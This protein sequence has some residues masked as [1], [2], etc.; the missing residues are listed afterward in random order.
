MQE[1][2]AD[3]HIH[4]TESDSTLTPEEVVEYAHKRGLST[5]AITDHDSIGAIDSVKDYARKYDIEVIPGVELSASYD[6]EEIHL[7]GYFLDYSS[8][9]FLKKLDF[10]KAEREDRTKNIIDK[11]KLLGMPLLFD[12][13]RDYATGGVMGRAH[14]AQV[15]AHKGY[16][17]SISQAF[18]LYLNKNKSAYV[19]KYKLLPKDAVSMIREINGI[20]VVAHP[21]ASKLSGIIHRLISDGIDGIEVFHGEHKEMASRKYLK[22]AKDNKLLVTGGSD[23]HGMM[24]GR[25]FLGEVKIGN[26]YLIPIRKRLLKNANTVN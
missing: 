11:L 2:Y 12:E 1:R 21:Y 5:I 14:I 7:L 13:V 25:V 24:K 8:Q 15:L 26:E 16:V 23:C 6:G 4:T 17:K 9:S 18:Y 10:F 19:P 3:L 20:C 22:I